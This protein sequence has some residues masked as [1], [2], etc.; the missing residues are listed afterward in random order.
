MV[1]VA[2]STWDQWS[3][4]WSTGRRSRSPSRSKVSPFYSESFD[5][6]RGG[7]INFSFKGCYSE[8]GGGGGGSILAWIVILSVC[9]A[10]TIPEVK[11]LIS[12]FSADLL[13]YEINYWGFK[14]FTFIHN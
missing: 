13:M 2:R 12:P 6:G 4:T 10:D 7:G 14:P 1:Y 5:V 3:G 11:L 9:D 8:T